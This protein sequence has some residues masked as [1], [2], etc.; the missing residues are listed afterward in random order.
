[1]FKE[2]LGKHK[3]KKLVSEISVTKEQI[4]ELLYS[5]EDCTIVDFSYDAPTGMT[6]IGMS[7]NPYEVINQFE[8]RVKSEYKEFQAKL[9]VYRTKS[10][11]GS[12]NIEHQINISI[13]ELVDRKS[14]TPRKGLLETA[15]IKYV[16]N[17]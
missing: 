1:M 4:E 14:G 2:I 16:V 3:R 7:D 11:N 15:N 12:I 6:S 10:K 13:Q 9:K 8:K 5:L 17:F